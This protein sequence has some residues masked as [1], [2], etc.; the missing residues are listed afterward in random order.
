MATTTEKVPKAKGAIVRPMVEWFAGACGEDA[1]RDVVADL[2][3]EV[4]REI[5]LDAPALGILPAG[6]YTESL[7]SQ[8]ADAILRHA[9]AQHT[10]AVVVRQLGTRIIDRTLGRLSR[11]AVEWLATPA[12]VAAAAPIFWRMYHDSGQVE[13]R[14]DG[15]SIVAT[16]RAW[17][18]HS[19]N[20]CRVVGASCVRVL[21]L[22]RCRDARVWVHKCSN[23]RGE[24]SLVFRWNGTEAPRA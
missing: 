4:Q 10:D 6:W 19:T 5:S 2:S 1:L 7:A 17:A 9:S 21:E 8:L 24:C 18:P 12:T 3:L 22:A 23:G 20:W 14:L 13:G 15:S 11:A 16:S